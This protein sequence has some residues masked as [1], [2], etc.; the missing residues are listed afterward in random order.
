MKTENLK[1]DD[2]SQSEKDC[3]PNNGAGKE[4][5][6]YLRVSHNGKTI[7][8]ESDAMEPEDCVFYR[9]LSWIEPLL[10]K[11]FLLGKQEAHEEIDDMY[12]PEFKR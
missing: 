11:V 6:G 8:L 5:A 3:V 1:Y 2:L 9:D 10:H 7:A 12:P 4:Y